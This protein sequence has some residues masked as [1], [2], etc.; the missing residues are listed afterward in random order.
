MTEKKDRE[1]ERKDSR[2]PR[3]FTRGAYIHHGRLAAAAAAAA[4]AVAVEHTAK[5]TPAQRMNSRQ[6][7]FSTYSR[8]YV[9]NIANVGTYMQS[10]LGVGGEVR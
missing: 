1:G 6:E 10:A 9:R 4:A 5:A 2:L 8:I 3:R 7:V